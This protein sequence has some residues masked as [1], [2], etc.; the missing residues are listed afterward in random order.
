MRV[1]VVEDEIRIRKGMANLIENHTEHTVIGEAQNGKEGVEL[2]L[3]YVPDLIITDIRMP[4]MDG[5][6]MM[7]QLREHDGEWHFV[8]LSGYSEFA[9]AKKAL[10]YGADDYLIKPL[11]PDDVIELL[12]KIQE[13]L[14]KERQKRQEKPEQMLRNYLVEKEDIPIEQLE[15]V[16]RFEPDEQWRMVSAYVGNL[17]K[18]DRNNCISRINRL[19]ADYPDEKI[20]Y[21]FTESTREFLVLL[22]EELWSGFKREIENKLLN[23]RAA[24]RAWIWVTSEIKDI[25]EI[26]NVYEKLEEYYEYALVF[27]AGKIIDKAYIE[28]FTPEEYLSSQ[29]NKKELQKFFYKKDQQQFQKEMTKFTDEMSRLKIRPR[30]IKEEYLQ[31]AYFLSNLAKENDGRIYE[32]LQNLNVIQNIG[33]AVTEHELKSIFANMVQVFLNNM[34]G[35]QNISNY[36]ILRAIDYIRNHFQEGISLESVAENLDITPEYLSTL[37]NREVGENFTSFLKKFRISYAKRL[38]RETDKKI[39]EIADEVGYTDPKY[40]NRVFKEEEG[41]SPGDFRSLKV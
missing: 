26:R 24:E 10:Q 3:L 5:L 25:K 15:E 28:N 16:C 23:R 38:L 33:N 37:F 14:R 7:R 8:I 19:K 27:D 9:Y 21:F 17:P 39:Y 32:Q 11:A 35:Q 13:R 1:L 22:K 41:I 29:R 4:V 40:F 6:E 30:Q 12:D 2:A 36:V 18:E 31:M 34:N 20:Y